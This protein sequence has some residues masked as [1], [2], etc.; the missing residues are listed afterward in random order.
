MKTR[1][2]IQPTPADSPEQRARWAQLDALRSQW[3]AG[4]VRNAVEIGRLS[5]EIRKEWLEKR[6]AR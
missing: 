6:R 3:L 2:H 4:G 5:Q 1:G